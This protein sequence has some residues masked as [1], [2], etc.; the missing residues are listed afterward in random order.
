MNSFA[1]V[2]RGV[3]DEE[4]CAELLQCINRKGFTPVLISSGKGKQSL[5][6]TARDG[7][8]VTVDCQELVNWLFDVVRPHIPEEL[9]GMRLVDLNKRCRF[10]FYTPGQYFAP[11]L[12]ANFQ[13]TSGKISRVT[14]Q[15]YLHNV[16][17]ENGGATTFLFQGSPP[18]PCQPGAGSL[19]IFKQDLLHEGSLIKHGLKYTFRTEAFYQ[20]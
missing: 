11:H 13:D 15:V 19:L 1:R 2:V 3:M 18:L 12:D 10:L 9:S 14:L 16:P 4:D 6:A 7:F 20:E 8:R 5:Q 17:V